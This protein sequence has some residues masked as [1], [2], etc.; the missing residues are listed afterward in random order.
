MAAPLRSGFVFLTATGAAVVLAVVPLVGPF[1]G[2]A[3]CAPLLA[4]QA[5]D[6][7]LSRRGLDARGKKDWHQRWRGE[8]VGFGLAALVAL[9]VPFVCALLPPA[10][11]VGGARLV[12]DLEG[13]DLERGMPT[14]SRPG[15]SAEELPPETTSP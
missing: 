6:P 12:L 14:S 7:I 1:L 10:L 13:L 8:T 15:S 2:A 3:L 9:L 11:A 4:Y 5:T